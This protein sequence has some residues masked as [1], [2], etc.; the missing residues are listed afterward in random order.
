[1]SIPVVGTPRSRVDGPD[2][3]TGAAKYTCDRVL[4][5]M[6]HAVV[7]PS[8]IASGRIVAIDTEAARKA[9][10]VALVMTHEN[11]PRA[12]EKKSGPQDSVL[13]LLQ[14]DIVEFDRQPVAVV[15][16]QTFEQAVYGADLVRVRYELHA[17]Q[18]D[19]DTGTVFTPI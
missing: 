13:Y 11:A 5:G 4:P 19:L 17:P 3:V 9:S 14:S 18:M 7:V 8:T 15:V 2:K 6:L 10:G 12:N 1:M 16:A